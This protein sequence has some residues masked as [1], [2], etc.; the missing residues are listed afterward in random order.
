MSDKAIVREKVEALRGV[1]RTWF[2]W[3]SA[4]DPF[5]RELVVEVDAETDPNTSGFNSALLDAISAEV[6]HVLE[7]ETTMQVQSLRIVPKR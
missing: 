5:K 7:N 4:G 2:E 3:T 1:T 6:A